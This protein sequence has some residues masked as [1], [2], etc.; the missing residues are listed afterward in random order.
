[1]ARSPGPLAELATKFP[2]QVE[3]LEAELSGPTGID[4]LV[5][6]DGDS[7]NFIHYFGG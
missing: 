1:M 3:P 2:Q 6:A 4:A 7:G 5:A